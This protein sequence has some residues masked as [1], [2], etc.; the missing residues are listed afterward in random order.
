MFDCGHHM[1]S[2]V[3]TDLV[4]GECIF[5]AALIDADGFTIERT[6]IDLKPNE[7]AAILDIVESYDIISIVTT[8]NI[9]SAKLFSTG[10]TLIIQTPKNGNVGKARLRLE[11]SYP[12]IA[13]YLQ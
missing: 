1:L 13:K 8:E 5:S 6:S 9:L 10:H 2:N 4:D 12:L 3:I 7:M 11:Q